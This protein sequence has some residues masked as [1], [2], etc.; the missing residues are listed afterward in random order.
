MHS[1][2]LVAPALFYAGVTVLHAVLP[3]WVRAGY[4]CKWD[5]TPIVYRLNAPLAFAVSILLF[6]KLVPAE[7]ASFAA[8]EFWACCA[9][10]NA[11]GLLAAAAL[12]RYTTPS[13]A[14]RCLTVDQTELRKKAAK[15]DD[16]QMLVAPAPERSTAA[17]FFFGV[18]F[19]PRVGNVDLKMLLYLLGAAGLEVLLLSALA[20]R[21][22]TH[23]ELSNALLLYACMLS[24]FVCEYTLCEVVHLYTYDLFCEKL[25]FKICWG[26][27]AFYPAFYCVGVWP[28][29]DAPSAA[30]LPATTC[31][32]I[33]A[34]FMA[35]W[36]LTRGANLQKFALKTRGR[37][38]DGE[39]WCGLRM[40]LVPGTRLLCSGFWGIS[41]HVNYLGEIVQAVALALPG[42]LVSRG[43][44]PYYSA[45][46]WLYPLYYV[47]LFIPRQMDD[48]SQMRAKYGEK[49]FAEYVRRVPSRIVPGVW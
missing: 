7:H 31:A 49:A 13:P 38:H 3:A 17:H 6:V 5:G 8:R 29:L 32:A 33:G 22:E 11:L 19:N 27:L 1:F 30:D 36:V 24:W 20:L 12:L 45:L 23:G 47:A 39:R 15:G 16:V 43:A 35:G 25:G 41:R 21:R 48:D 42:F 14:F 4:A 34:L 40:S 28:L 46:P 37:A 10:A 9:G 44:P 18:E 2:A 26:C